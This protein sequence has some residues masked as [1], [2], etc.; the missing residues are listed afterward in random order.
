MICSLKGHASSGSSK[1][2]EAYPLR[3]IPCSTIVS[4][5]SCGVTRND[6]FY[7]LYIFAQL[8]QTIVPLYT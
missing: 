6:L 5:I 2:M 7:G 3:P 1:D 8:S 4:I